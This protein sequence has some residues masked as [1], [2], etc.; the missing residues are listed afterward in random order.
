MNSLN[1]D[2]IVYGQDPGQNQKKVDSCLSALSPSLFQYKRRILYEGSKSDHS[3]LV[4]DVHY[5]IDVPNINIEGLDGWYAILALIKESIIAQGKKSGLLVLYGVERA[6]TNLLYAVEQ[7]LGPP[8]GERVRLYCW[9]ATSSLSCLGR[10]ILD[11]CEVVP[12]KSEGPTS[13]KWYS[14]T[15]H[16]ISS[17]LMTEIS[18]GNKASIGKIRTYLYELTVA[19][20]TIHDVAWLLLQKFAVAYEAS[21]ELTYAKLEGIVSDM[22]DACSSASKGYRPILHLEIMVVQLALAFDGIL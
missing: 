5:E 15:C 6:S 9:I 16:N 7:C 4:T 10:G 2:I 14:T 1:K 21:G 22:M 19:G 18:K 20:L 17:R 3:I 13:R 11:C 12:V 8:L